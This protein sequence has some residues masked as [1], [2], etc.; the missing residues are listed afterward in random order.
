MQGCVLLAQG[1]TGIA[2]IPVPVSCR[3]LLGYSAA[4]TQPLCSNMTCG[5]RFPNE[6]RMNLRTRMDVLLGHSSCVHAAA[7]PNNGILTWGCTQHMC[8]PMPAKRGITRTFTYL[9]PHTGSPHTKSGSLSFFALRASDRR[10][11]EVTKYSAGPNHCTDF[12]DAKE[13]PTT[14]SI[15]E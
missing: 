5:C 11:C 14:P 1:C 3:C 10:H 12:E 8:I 9:N 13:L 7:S 6:H 15:R 2:Y 4:Q